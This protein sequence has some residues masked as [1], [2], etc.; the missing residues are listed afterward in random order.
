M[1]EMALQKRKPMR[2][3]VYILPNKNAIS[4]RNVLK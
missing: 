3:G 1:Q 2:Q 4:L